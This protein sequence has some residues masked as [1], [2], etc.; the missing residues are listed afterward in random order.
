M[1]GLNAVK[2]RCDVAISIDADLQDDVNAIPEMLER[3][4]E[5]C[6]IVYGVR[7]ERKTDTFFK[8]TTA[9]T[10]YKLMKIMGVKSVYNH[11][12]YRL[13][14]CVLSNNFAVS[15]SAISIC[16]GWCLSSVTKPPVFTI[17]AT[18]VLPESRNIHSRRC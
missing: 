8:R 14:S 16:A 9:L 10:F 4:R 5:G 15:A 3:Y 18:S 12:D 1:A 11:A 17:I 7:R 6:D 2:E 13:M